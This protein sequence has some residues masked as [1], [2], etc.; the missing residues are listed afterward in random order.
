[1]KIDLR[2]P[3]CIG[4]IISIIA[5]DVTIAEFCSKVLCTG[6]CYTQ[7]LSGKQF[8]SC[9]QMQR[10]LDL[11]DIKFQRNREA[12]LHLHY[13][14]TNLLAKNIREQ[15]LDDI[16]GDLPPKVY[17]ALVLFEFNLLSGAKK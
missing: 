7:Y 14:H 11:G 10:I 15:T 1:M 9:E 12:I 6:E 16:K 17:S 3:K 2:D 13:L 4:Q 5:K 8:P